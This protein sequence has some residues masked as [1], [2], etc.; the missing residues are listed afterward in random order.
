MLTADPDELARTDISDR[1][2][3]ALRCSR[4]QE[5]VIA[6]RRG[7]AQSAFTL[8]ELIGLTTTADVV[9][10]TQ[11]RELVRHE[12]ATVSDTVTRRKLEILSKLVDGSSASSRPESGWPTDSHPGGC[13]AGGA[14]AA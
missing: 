3:K 14:P 6:A 1:A 13:S 4:V 8:P 7:P 11:D 12:L 5:V 2:L 9:L 10:D